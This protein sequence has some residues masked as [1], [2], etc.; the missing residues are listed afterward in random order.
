MHICIPSRYSLIDIRLS[1]IRNH[2]SFR[3]ATGALN[4]LR[5]PD[6]D[7]HVPLFLSTRC[8]SR[9]PRTWPPS[10]CVCLSPQD[11]SEEVSSSTPESPFVRSFPL[12]VLRRKFP[13]G[14]SAQSLSEQSIFDSFSDIVAGFFRFPSLFAGV[15]H[16]SVFFLLVAFFKACA[17]STFASIPGFV[18][19]FRDQYSI[20]SISVLHMVHGVSSRRDIVWRLLIDAR[21]SWPKACLCV[22]GRKIRSPVG[23]GSHHPAAEHVRRRQSQNMG[24]RRIREA[25]TA[26]PWPGGSVGGSRDV[27]EEP[28][29]AT[30]SGIFPIWSSFCS[31]ETQSCCIL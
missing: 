1:A 6:R 10:R 17:I 28:G 7:G 27:D 5:L 24:D 31:R 26:I 21:G 22:R 11:P 16:V 25:V 18:A 30:V 8:P 12:S 23:G 3:W 15:S 9:F 14:L 29:A 20:H 4:C 13:P 19:G 2:R